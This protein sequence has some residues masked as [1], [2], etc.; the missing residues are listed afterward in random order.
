MTL[1]VLASR[2]IAG[3]QAP[4]VRVETHLG[5][6]LPAFAIVGLPDVEV[7]ESRERV[8]AAI[9]NS[10]FDFPPG[11]ITV[12]L[13]SADLPKASARFDLPIAL[14][15]LLASGQVAASAAQTAAL[16]DSVWAAELSLSGALVPPAAPLALALAVAREQPGATL[17]LPAGSAAVAAWVPGIRVLAAHTLGE[18]AAYLAGHAELA[19][20]E[21]RA[22]PEAEPGPCL[23]D[24]RGQP[25]ARRA[26]EVAAA[27]GHSLLMCGPPGAGK[28]MLAQRLPS[29]LPP[30]EQGQALEVAAIAGAVGAPEVLPG[31][32]PFRAPHHSASSAAL[33]GGGARPRPGEIS[34]AHHGVLFLDELPEFERRALE[35]LREPLETGKVVISRAL[36]SVEYPAVFQ[37]VAAMNPCPCGWRGHASKACRCTPDQVRRYAAR[38][39][40]PLVDRIDLWIEL[41]ATEP[42]WLAEPPGEPSLPVRER[43]VRCRQRQLARQGCLNARLSG[44]A[45]D[46]NCGLGAA[47]RALLQQAMRRL[48]GSA[49]AAHRALRVARTVADLAGEREI[50]AAHIA[51]AVQYRRPV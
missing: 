49:R 22:W 3:W 20:A 41:P 21:R 28:S 38:V 48:G 25:A 7:R 8:R 2:A 13:S 51:E 15:I 44:P 42:Q 17:V 14:G 39:S 50:G 46:A 31:Q 35:S 23:S 9:Q 36:H 19:P 11:R 1:A 6:G 43:V 24:V 34:L 4:A 5:S 45:L 16:P 37:L 27:G 32:P 29:L 12:N 47:A 18:A 30:L 40:G 10:G 33:V 26:L